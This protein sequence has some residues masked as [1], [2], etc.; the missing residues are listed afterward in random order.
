[1]ACIWELSQIKHTGIYQE[2]LAEEKDGEVFIDG[3]KI[4]TD[5]G[6][7][8]VV[9]DL[10]EHNVKKFEFKNLKI[11][12][13]IFDEDETK[14]TFYSKINAK[15]G[16]ALDYP[17]ERLYSVEIDDETSDIYLEDYQLTPLNV[18][19]KISFEDCEIDK[20]YFARSNFYCEL[21]FKKN[22]FF[23]SFLI[24]EK[25]FLERIMF[26][27]NTFEETFWIDRSEF[28]KAFSFKAH[29]G[30]E[31][32]NISLT[33]SNFCGEVFL[34]G[35][36]FGGFK[37][38]NSVFEKNIYF[39][40][41]S[42]INAIEG[43]GYSSFNQ[44]CLLK[45]CTFKE[46][47]YFERCNFQFCIIDYCIFQDDSFFD[48]STFFEI[49]ISK[50][51]FERRTSFYHSIF[52][53]PPLFAN[54][55][56]DKY[57]TMTGS[58]LA[59]NS[60]GFIEKVR[61]NV[62]NLCDTHNNQRVGTF[63]KPNDRWEPDD[64]LKDY[65][66]GFCTIKNA[67]IK[68]NNLLDASNYHKVELCCME[69]E[70]EKKNPKPFSKDWIDK[71]QLWFYRQTSEHHTDLLRSFNTLIALIGIFGLLC[72][73]VVLG[74]D[75]FVFDYQKG[76]DIL[77]LKSFFFDNISESI[78]SH[79]LGY[80]VGN[81]VLV[82]VFLGLFLGVMWECSRK[83]LIPLGYMATFG[84]LATSPKYLIPAMSLFGGKWVALNP[85]GT[86][87]G[88]YT[89]LFGFLAYSFI[90]TARKNSIIPS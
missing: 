45:H 73:S 28:Q 9:L 79:L 19:I 49:R 71:W 55:I 81:V 13:I 87:G 63:S 53:Q 12:S 2:F 26:L 22:T 85:L 52:Q 72:G 29:K 83:V 77:Q 57:L 69:L 80:F 74:L 84:F 78:T 46:K 33:Y 20:V 51:T 42:Q 39:G 5:D 27:D 41:D 82:F 64:F 15:K 43:F 40:I 35:G 24:I 58:K 32:R 17:K 56:F 61:K 60:S 38:E 89:L 50:T 6:K 10:V 90:K 66:D 67:L 30:D 37:I 23:K 62:I 21:E 14:I 76:F 59:L 47:A 4:Y 75:Y 34:F 54:C 16:D 18:P 25:I 65:R 36:N 44:Y 31:N 88:I 3:D 8:V 68:N 86:I 48:Y 11:E 7:I 70:L 1:M